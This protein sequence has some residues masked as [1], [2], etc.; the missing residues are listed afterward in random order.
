[1]WFDREELG[2][3]VQIGG[4][5]RFSIPTEGGFRQN[6]KS[7]AEKHAFLYAPERMELRFR[8][9]ETFCLPS[10]KNQTDTDFRVGV[11]IGE[12]MPALY[13]ARLEAL[14]ADIP[15]ATLISRPVMAHH[16]VV[17]SAYN[18]IFDRKT[19]I[20]LSFR[21]DDDD[22][23]AVDY[24]AEVRARLPALLEMSGGLEM[25]PVCL[26]YSYGLTLHGEKG[27]RSIVAAHYGAPVSAGLAVLAPADAKP[28]VMIVEHMRMRMHM[29]TI[30]DPGPVMS[31]R[32][33]HETNDSVPGTDMAVPGSQSAADLRNLIATRFK[34][35]LDTILAV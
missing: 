34:L 13:R 22:A 31:L 23:L 3:L 15:Q 7:H 18:E 26:D 24:I 11:L 16:Q 10:L 33:L 12:D 30:T 21:L 4:L 2:D 19:P 1:M 14:L 5:I 32:T 20:R 35:D 6:P 29:A 9:F 25:K 28:L 17:T 27:E 8:Y